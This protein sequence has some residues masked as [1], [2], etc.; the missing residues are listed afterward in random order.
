[1]DQLLEESASAA[2]AARTVEL[3]AESSAERDEP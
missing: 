2:P 3:R 1:L